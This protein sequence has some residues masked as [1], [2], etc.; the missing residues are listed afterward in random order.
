LTDL[1]ILPTNLTSRF[2]QFS[3]DYLTN[4]KGDPQYNP[5]IS[6][7]LVRIPGT[8]NS[9][10]GQIVKVVQRWDGQRPAIQYLLRQF[11]RW[12]IDEKIEQRRQINHRKLRANTINSTTK[13][14]WI[15]NLLQTPIE[16]NRKFAVWRILVPYLINIRR[17]ASEEAYDTIRSW[18]DKCNSLRRLNFNPSYMIRRNI[19]TAKRGGYLPISLDKLRRESTYLYEVVTSKKDQ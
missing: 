8:I 2:M 19:S 18:L 17:L 14:R 11:R 15:E 9:K 6:S 16:D 7:C 10:C 1:L 4:K 3:V 5:T 12:L 13:I